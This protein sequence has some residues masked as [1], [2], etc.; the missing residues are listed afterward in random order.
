MAQGRP[1]Q[2]YQNTHVKTSS[3]K[4]LIVMLFDGMDRFMSRA[5][6]AIEEDDFEVAH[7]N[8]QKTGKILLELISTLREDTGGE[9]ASN[10]KKI[11]VY[12]YEQ[13]V[14]ANLKKD[15]KMVGDI[16]EVLN[17]LREGWKAISRGEN[18]LNAAGQTP[19]SI[20]ITG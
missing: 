19:K 3:Q 7:N 9:I 17:N 2:A 14:M 6:R 5:G 16:K 8:L 20:R 1:Y 11:Y 4:Q 12:C 13:I 10:L 15:A 18:A